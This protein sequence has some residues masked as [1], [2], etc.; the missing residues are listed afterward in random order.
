[1]TDQARLDRFHVDRPPD[2]DMVELTGRE[3]HHLVHVKRHTVGD[4]VAVVASDGGTWVGTIESLASRSARIAIESKC[5]EP[6]EAHLRLTLAFSP[7][8]G[9][10][11]DTL[12]EK[13][14]ELGVV[15][16]VPVICER[17][18]VRLTADAPKLARWR[19]IVIE[20]AKQC[21]RDR[22]PRVLDPMSF[23]EAIEQLEAQSKWIGALEDAV[24][25]RTAVT[26]A[27]DGATCFIGPE[28]GFTLEETAAAR[29][30][31]FQPVCL[32]PHV[33]RVETAAI[34][35]CALA[36]GLSSE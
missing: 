34:A 1:M 27:K 4:R 21:R 28:G 24:P 19:R 9:A 14:T 30:Q 29:A 31:G 7:P 35:A 17:T 15:E 8:K 23:R 22:V 16:L 36:I 5:C 12:V 32:G 10:R 6:E 25:L 2:S 33:L 13:C 3:F 20:A 11:A 18:V 26:E